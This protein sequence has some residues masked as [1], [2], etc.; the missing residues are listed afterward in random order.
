MCMT[1]RLHYL[2]FGNYVFWDRLEEMETGKRSTRMEV[3]NTFRHLN[4]E[5]FPFK[6][7]QRVGREC[8]T[9]TPGGSRTK[10]KKPV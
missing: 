7:F 8:Y 4:S 10:K 9:I 1:K 3:K 6:K 2:H 5:E